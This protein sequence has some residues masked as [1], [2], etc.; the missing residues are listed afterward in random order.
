HFNE[1]IAMKRFGR[2]ILFKETIR[3]EAKGYHKLKKQTGGPGQFAVVELRVRP[4]ERNG[5]FR[6][7]DSIVEGKIP[8][9]FIPSVEKGVR[10]ALAKGVLAEYPVADLEVEL[11]D[12]AHHRKDSH[13][14]DFQFAAAMALRDAL[15]R[16]RPAP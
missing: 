9:A 3:Q 5:G 8:S 6:F 7:I 12:G 10:E 1:V 2:D 14:R 16:A 15:G 4:L 13:A 11:I